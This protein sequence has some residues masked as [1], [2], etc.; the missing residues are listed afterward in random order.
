M[1][2]AFRA[3]NRPHSDP[4]C[5]HVYTKI[6][7]LGKKIVLF[8]SLLWTS[9]TTS[10]ISSV[11]F[12]SK[13]IGSFVPLIAITHIEGYRF[14][15]KKIFICTF[16]GSYLFIYLKCKCVVRAFCPRV[17][18]GEVNIKQ[19]PGT[20]ITAQMHADSY[21]NRLKNTIN[22]NDCHRKSPG[23]YSLSSAYS[24]KSSFNK[25]NFP[26]IRASCFI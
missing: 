24:S 26:E 20:Y 16:C 4:V 22:L 18:P 10:L 11:Q 21:T 13:Y 2:R 23:T 15:E 3:I 12:L 8:C 6:P 14:G 1:P 7:Q 25:N 19:A 17:V 5:T 9:C